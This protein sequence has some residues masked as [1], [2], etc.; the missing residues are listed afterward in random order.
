VV[1]RIDRGSTRD[2]TVSDVKSKRGSP[3]AGDEKSTAEINKDINLRE[4]QEGRSLS[5][6][7]G[8]ALYG[9]IGQSLRI[10]VQNDATDD[11]CTTSNK[12]EPR[13]DITTISSGEV[14]S[15]R[16]TSEEGA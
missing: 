7:R 16:I 12:I 15:K 4:R 14:I 10:V 1:R 5:R 9:G 3:P 8:E 11:F 2:C 6:R 13:G